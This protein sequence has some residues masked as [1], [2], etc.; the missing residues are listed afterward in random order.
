[1]EDQTSQYGPVLH[2]C[3]YLDWKGYEKRSCACVM[4]AALQAAEKFC[5]FVSR[6]YETV[7]KKMGGSKCCVL[8]C[9][10]TTNNSQYKFYR[11]PTIQHKL[12][13]RERW[14]SIVRQQNSFCTFFFCCLFPSFFTLMTWF[15]AQAGVVTGTVFGFLVTNGA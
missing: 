13:Q 12:I 8:S 11:F 9:K 15:T 3:K 5:N 2:S 10:N 6:F 1:M 7:N 4:R 14:I